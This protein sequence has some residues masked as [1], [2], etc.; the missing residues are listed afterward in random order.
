[1]TGFNVLLWSTVHKKEIPL[2]FIY[3]PI[4]LYLFASLLMV[5]NI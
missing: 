1:M 5:E 3:V 4:L 2:F